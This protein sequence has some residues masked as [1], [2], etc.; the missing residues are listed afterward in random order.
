[1]KWITLFERDGWNGIINND[2]E[3]KSEERGIIK[4]YQEMRL[5]PESG[6]DS[7]RL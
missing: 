6:T 7:P 2:N 3:R 5:A 1:M 4:K